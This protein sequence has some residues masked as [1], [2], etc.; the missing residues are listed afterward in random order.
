M[1]VADVLVVNKADGDLLPAARIAAA[2]LRGALRFQRPKHPNWTPQVL[3]ASAKEREASGDTAAISCLNFFAQCP[4]PSLLVLVGIEK[5]WETAE[6]F[7]Q[8]ML[9]STD[10][11]YD[12]RLR[13][14]ATR[15]LWR[16]FAVQ[17]GADT[18]VEALACSRNN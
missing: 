6:A 1:E 14:Q 16:N 7:R 18:Q 11:A 3:L 9:D 10:D 12:K 13:A 5:V 15:A 8:A 17:V 2:D 4:P